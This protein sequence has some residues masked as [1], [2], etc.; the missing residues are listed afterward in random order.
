LVIPKGLDLSIS[1]SIFTKNIFLD[2]KNATRQTI[3]IQIA[4]RQS[5][6]QHLTISKQKNNHPSFSCPQACKAV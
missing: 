3:P 4:I 6:P 2:E 5:D 1:T